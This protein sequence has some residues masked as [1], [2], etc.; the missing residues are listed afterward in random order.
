MLA[1][2]VEMTP[3]LRELAESWRASADPSVRLRGEV[4][5]PTLEGSWDEAA[6]SHPDP[7]VRMALLESPPDLSSRTL[8]VLLSAVEREVSGPV[9]M[10]AMRGL[11]VGLD[12]ERVGRLASRIRSE[13]E[14][15]ARIE[16]I[17][18]LATF[19]VAERPTVEALHAVAYSPAASVQERDAAQAALLKCADGHPGLMSKSEREALQRAMLN[20]ATSP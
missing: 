12:A 19:Q 1:R 2:D 10:A 6:Q 8:D 3:A 13:P 20:P 7:E 15:A 14:S 11:P 5:R 17:E 4:L 16:I 18:L 9:R